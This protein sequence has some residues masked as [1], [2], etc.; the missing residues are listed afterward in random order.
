MKN[1]TTWALCRRSSLARSTGRIITIDAPVVP[2]KLASAVPM[3]SS[4]VFA[5]GAPWMLPRMTMP[6]ATV[7]S[8]RSSRM[9]G[10][11]SKSA[12]W[13]RAPSAVPVPWTKAI[14]TRTSAA[15]KAAILPW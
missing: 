8:A 6:P 5:A 11:Y 10:T 1:T 9:K 7:K 12:V 13:A 3:A 2:M 15:H 4:A 14:G